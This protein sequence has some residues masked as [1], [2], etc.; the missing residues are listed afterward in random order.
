MVRISAGWRI[1]N[2]TLF[3]TKEK[4]WGTHFQNYPRRKRGATGEA[5]L[6]AGE[7][8]ERILK[9]ERWSMA[10]KEEIDALIQSLLT[11]GVF[12]WWWRKM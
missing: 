4:G 2:P 3:Q 11:A 7:S 6:W 9:G 10:I 5:G 8:G 12:G 1:L